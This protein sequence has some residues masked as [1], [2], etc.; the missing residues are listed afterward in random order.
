[1]A[2]L[3]PVT[4][5]EGRLL[6]ERTLALAELAGGIA[7]DF[8]NL[9]LAVRGYAELALGAAAE[10][11][12]RAHIERVIDAADKAASLTQQLLAFSRSR[13]ADP[14]V[15]DL[16]AVVTEIGTLLEC[17][18]ADDV[19]LVTVLDAELGAVEVDRSQLEQV[20]M[21]LIV[22]ARDAMPNGGRLEVATRNV[23]LDAA[24][25]AEL[26]G[27]PDPGAYVCVAVADNG[28]GVGADTAA[29]MFEPFFTTKAE[30]GGT[31][32]GLAT[33]S[34]IV[35][36]S[37]GGIGVESRD[38]GGT[39][40]R[41]Y[42]PRVSGAAPAELPEFVAHAPSGGETI[43]VVEDEPVVRQLVRELLERDGY[44]VHT[45]A[46]PAEALELWPSCDA[47][48]VI[49]DV[50]MPGMSGSQLVARLRETRPDVRVLYT[51]GYNDDAVVRSGV[52]TAEA[53]FLQ[54]PFDGASLARK[55]REVLDAP[56][57]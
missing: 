15:L 14:A 56:A 41:V 13:S 6:D 30:R 49:S 11:G 19:E 21:N 37:G 42:L 22:N 52:M 25:A 38:D 17:V 3:S 16:N 34:A 47:D 55:V 10:A 43:L 50:V 12:Q 45:A 40:F 39:E 26:V 29:R 53:A 4:V 36:R 57:P 28:S 7:H 5:P 27:E 2:V 35:R 20:L 54:K 44:D 31:G 9:L 32:L 18:V 8:N 46:S 33:V 51:S 48:L 24:S 23:E 1:M